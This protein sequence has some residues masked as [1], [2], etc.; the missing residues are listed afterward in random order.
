[1]CL[2]VVCERIWARAAPQ[3]EVCAAGAG[4]E[5]TEETWGRLNAAT[6]CTSS[7][8]A[9]NFNLLLDTTVISVPHRLLFILLLILLQP[10]LARHLQPPSG[11]V[12][13][14][15]AAFQRGP[16]EGA[17]LKAE[18]RKPALAEAL[19]DETCPA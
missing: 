16:S 4:G 5:V 18:L 3:A 9:L 10:P 17:R 6:S 1:M 11:R 15:L 2:L 7:V 14:L 12:P 19:L 8:C 13:A